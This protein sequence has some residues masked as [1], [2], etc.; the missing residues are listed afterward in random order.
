[1]RLDVVVSLHLQNQ[2]S[3]TAQIKPEPDILGQVLPEFR[4]T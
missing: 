1:M 4:R 3:S 2:V